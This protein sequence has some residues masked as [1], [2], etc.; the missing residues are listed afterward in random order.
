MAN[1]IFCD[2]DGV[3]NHSH[4]GKDENDKFGFADDCIANLKK[5]LIAVP[6]TK[7]VISSAWKHFTM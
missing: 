7:I 4:F 1:V 5:I 3:L 6:D 2:I